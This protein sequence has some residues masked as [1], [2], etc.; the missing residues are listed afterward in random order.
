MKKTDLAILQALLKQSRA[1]VIVGLPGSGKTTFAEECSKY[2]TGEIVHTD[3]YTELYG[4]GPSLYN[5]LDDLDSNAQDR[6]LVEGVLGYRLLRKIAQKIFSGL[7]VGF[8]PD[9]VITV[10]RSKEQRESTMVMRGKTSYAA[11]DKALRTIWAQY[12]DFVDAC[13]GDWQARELV[14]DM[15]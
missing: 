13:D 5:L 3:E 14:I 12:R 7:R 10:Y 15:S 6:I 8:K 4:Y 1:V 9:L 2:W 11:M